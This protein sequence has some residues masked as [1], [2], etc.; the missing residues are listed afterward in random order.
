MASLSKLAEISAYDGQTEQDTQ[1]N[2]SGSSKSSTPTTCPCF[3]SPSPSCGEQDHDLCMF[4]LN[5]A[6]ACTLQPQQNQTGE[7]VVVYHEPNG[8][9]GFTPQR[10]GRLQRIRRLEDD[11]DG[12]TVFEWVFFVAEPGS[13]FG[14]LGWYHKVGDVFDPE[15]TS[16]SVNAQPWPKCDDGGVLWCA[17]TTQTIHSTKTLL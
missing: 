13:D 16:T 1:K 15:S 7:S 12:S 3:S 6:C 5:A 14:L 17:N 8:D 10:G 9:Q 11:G 4:A 2:V